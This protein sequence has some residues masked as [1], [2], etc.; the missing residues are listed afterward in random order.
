[1]PFPD[2]PFATWLP[3]RFI[4]VFA[5]G[6]FLVDNF[7][8]IDAK[9]IARDADIIEKGGPNRKDLFKKSIP[10]VVS[11]RMFSTVRLIYYAPLG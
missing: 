7:V 11:H 3:E 5:L 8:Q 10:F 1:L 6:R 2:M 9:L 4:I